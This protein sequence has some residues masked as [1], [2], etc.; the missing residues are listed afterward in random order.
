MT[1]L[2]GCTAVPTTEY[3]AALP[4]GVRRH[5]FAY[6]RRTC[7]YQNVAPVCR[8]FNAWVNDTPGRQ[9]SLAQR[10]QKWLDEVLASMRFVANLVHIFCLTAIGIGGVITLAVAA[11]THCK[12][13]QVCASTWLGVTVFTGIDLRCLGLVSSR[14]AIR[15]RWARAATVFQPYL[16]GWMWFAVLWEPYI[17][18]RT[19]LLVQ[20]AAYTGYTVTLFVDEG[21]LCWAAWWLARNPLRMYSVYKAC[22]YQKQRPGV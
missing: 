21:L 2:E 22:V 16:L 15:R 4:K 11:S 17:C 18:A 3:I 19:E 8:A 5:L 6:V 7:G 1:E 10:R 9:A 13:V 14:H 12:M 20:V